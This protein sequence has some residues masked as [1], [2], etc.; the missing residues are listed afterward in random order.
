MDTYRKRHPL[1]TKYYKLVGSAGLN[2]SLNDMIGYVQYIMNHPEYFELFKPQI[3]TRS[4]LWMLDNNDVKSADYGYG[5]RLLNYRGVDVVWHPGFLKGMK[6]ATIIIPEYDVALIV[7]N[8]SNKAIWKEIMFK[9]I[10]NQ[11]F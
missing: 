5:W 3:K 1:S 2:G 10:D 7:M 11:F 8:H 9:F 6:P 4:M